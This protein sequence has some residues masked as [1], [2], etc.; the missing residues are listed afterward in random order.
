MSTKDRLDAT[1]KNIEGKAQEAA[2][3]VTGDKSDQAKGKAKQAQASGQHAVED[4]KDN[5][6]KVVDKA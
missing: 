3:K 2:G 1:A 5:V 6:K 4:V